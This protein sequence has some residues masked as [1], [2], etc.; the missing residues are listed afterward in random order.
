[1]RLHKRYL[2]LTAVLGLGLIAALSPT[3][4]SSVAPSIS[5]Y[6][7]PGLYGAAKHYWMPS[8][9]TVSPGG[10]VKFVNPYTETYHGLKFTG[11]SAGVAPSCTGI[12][13]AA[14][15][16][17][18][19]L[20]RW[21]GE[22]TFSKP[23][24]YTFICTVHPTEMTGTITVPGTPK[25]KTTAA[26]G[27]NQSEATLNGSIEPE[28]NA[29]EY[30]FEYGESV[31]E[32]TTA[33]A[34]LGATDF[35]SH[36]VSASLTS[37]LPN[38]TYHFELIVTYGAGT[39]VLGG[40]QTFKTSAAT[41]PTVVA[42]SASGLTETEARLNGKVDPNGEATE[43]AFQYSTSPSYGQP[44]F[45]SLPADNV[46]H[47]VSAT[48]TKLTPGTLYYFKLVAKS[49]SGEK[50]AEG[51]FKTLSPTEGTPPPTTTT[52]STTPPPATTPVVPPPPKT[53]EILAPV[54]EGSLKLTV[55]RHGSSVRG[56]LDV[57]QSGAGGRLEV[58]LLAKSALLARRV[59]SKPVTVGRFVRSAVSAGKA[60]FSVELNRRGKSALRRHRRLALTVKIVLTPPQGKSVTITRSVVLHA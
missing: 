9:A 11:G 36:S 45:T 44:A 59:H 4:A 40:E 56:S 17:S 60:S 28:G 41:A 14:T 51:T 18:G 50:S 58:D 20:G 35:A 7:E 55:P 10:A 24:T 31:S 23:G 5:A 42:E 38:R 48:L 57:S 32:H 33:T 1:M 22:C 37:L 54:V 27:E 3:I 15:E 30:H 43:Y 13:Q 46:N 8:T 12:P 34:S 21:E 26:S 39:T 29:T 53:E 47:P 2:W 6:N 16:P 52:T 25:A 49:K 19:A